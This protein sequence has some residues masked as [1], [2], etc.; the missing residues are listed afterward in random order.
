MNYYHNMGNSV[1]SVSNMITYDSHN[2]H[3]IIDYHI[4]N[5]PFTLSLT[6]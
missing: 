1:D 4:I 6:R 3:N 5:R 2:S